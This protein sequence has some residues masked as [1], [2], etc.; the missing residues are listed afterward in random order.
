MH[1]NIHT[2]IQ[3]YINTYP[4]MYA[5][6][7]TY[8]QTYIHTYMHIYVRTH[9]QIGEHTQ[10]DKQ[11]VR[12]TYTYTYTKGRQ[13]EF[14]SYDPRNKLQHAVCLNACYCFRYIGIHDVTG[15]LYVVVSDTGS[16]TD[17]VN[18]NQICTLTHTKHYHA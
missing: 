4:Y 3:T 11:T 18:M 10:T 6:I 14:N 17:A 1:I 9:N 8:I 16:D 5:Y 2:R 13:R 7:L 12:Q 15:E